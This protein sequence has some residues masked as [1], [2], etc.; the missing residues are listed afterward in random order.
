MQRAC[1]WLVLLEKSSLCKTH[2]YARVAR[3]LVGFAR[4]NRKDSILALQILPSI[5]SSTDRVVEDTALSRARKSGRFLVRS[6]TKIG[7]FLV[8]WRAAFRWNLRRWPTNLGAWSFLFCDCPNLG[9]IIKRKYK[10]GLYNAKKANGL[11]YLYIN[12]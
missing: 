5:G 4:L 12:I 11:Y 8:P 3:P 6:L 2:R 10:S 1:S 9:S 7:H